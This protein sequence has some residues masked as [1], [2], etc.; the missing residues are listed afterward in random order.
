MQ[1]PPFP[2]HL[3]P[4]RPK[5]SPQ[6]HIL[7]HPQLPFPPQCQRPS[8][9]PVEKTG[10]FPLSFY[11][12]QILSTLVMEA[13][14]S[15][16]AMVPS[17]TLQG[18]KVHKA[19]NTNDPYCPKAQGQ[20]MF[21]TTFPPGSQKHPTVRI[22][23]PRS[24]VM[25]LTV[26]VAKCE[27]SKHFLCQEFL[28]LNCIKQHASCG[29][30]HKTCCHDLKHGY[31]TRS[32]FT[33]FLESSGVKFR[34]LLKKGFQFGKR[35]N[36]GEW[37]EILAQ[38]LIPVYITTWFRGSPSLTVKYLWS[39]WEEDKS[40]LDKFRWILCSN[41]QRRIFLMTHQIL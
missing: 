24:T 40:V 20:N 26:A 22:T 37:M 27:N 30:S 3:V 19:T 16:E 34:S 6:H 13:T 2:R 18:T 10:N 23:H 28:Y 21:S 11:L 12:D 41:G 25:M 4:P 38:I 7:K 5:Y 35:N 9:T 32:A 1:S 31:G 8:F 14:G 36:A 15:S 33:S 29:T 39:S 17:T